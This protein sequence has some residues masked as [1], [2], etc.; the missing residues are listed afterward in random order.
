MSIWHTRQ[1]SFKSF[2]RMDGIYLGYQSTGSSPEETTCTLLLYVQADLFSCALLKLITLI[3][4]LIGSFLEDTNIFYFFCWLSFYP[5][6]FF[7]LMFLSLFLWTHFC[8]T[9]LDVLR[10]RARPLVL[11]GK[12]LLFTQIVLKIILELSAE[13]PIILYFYHNIS[14]NSIVLPL[15]RIYL[16]K[17]YLVRQSIENQDQVPA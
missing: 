16:R 1:N 12:L 15:Q 14:A 4:P 10:R 9:M 8:M 3:I 13:M 11:M 7:F 2:K 5:I 6:F 17:Y